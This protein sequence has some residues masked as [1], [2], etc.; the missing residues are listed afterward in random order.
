MKWG[1]NAKQHSVRSRAD[2]SDG[3]SVLDDLQRLA[4]LVDVLAPDNVGARANL[5]TTPPGR[6]SSF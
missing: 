3:V 1:A 5:T 6:T 2:V 4:V